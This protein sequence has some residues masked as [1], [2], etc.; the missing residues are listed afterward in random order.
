MLRA[1]AT[2]RS[3]RR[4][5]SASTVGDRSGGDERCAEHPDYS[6]PAASGACAVPPPQ[7]GCP[8]HPPQP[9]EHAQDAKH[10]A[11][12]GSSRPPGRLDD[13]R[14]GAGICCS[15]CT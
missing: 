10:R 15:D 2:F 13:V 1:M 14:A 4:S 3:S 11:A 7:A 8:S 5:S 6:V 12:R 9:G